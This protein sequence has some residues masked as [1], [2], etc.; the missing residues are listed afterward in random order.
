L[1]AVAGQC[2]RCHQIMRP[3]LIHGGNNLKVDR[4]VNTGMSKAPALNLA[5][6][7][8][9][10]RLYLAVHARKAAI[11][12]PDA[13]R[14]QLQTEILQHTGRYIRIGSGQRTGPLGDGGTIGRDGRVYGRRSGVEKTIGGIQLL[15]WT[16]ILVR[17]VAEA[18]I[19]KLLQEEKLFG[20]RLAVWSV[21]D[22]IDVGNGLRIVFGGWCVGTVTTDNK[23]AC[24]TA[25]NLDRG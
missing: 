12:I 13:G 17:R 5:G 7:D 20:I 10:G 9:H 25:G 18:G 14:K 22:R 15:P 8:G 1:Q 16:A 2:G 11:G 3:G 24:G 21:Q 6:C 4:V 19:G 23:N